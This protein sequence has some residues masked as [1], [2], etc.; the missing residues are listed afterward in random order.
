[1][2]VIFGKPLQTYRIYF[3]KVKKKMNVQADSM[4]PYQCFKS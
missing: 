3:E 1:M 4:L 2:V